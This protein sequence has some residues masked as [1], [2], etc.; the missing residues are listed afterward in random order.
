MTYQIVEKEVY[1]ETKIGDDDILIRHVLSMDA[2]LTMIDSVTLYK[3]IGSSFSQMRPHDSSISG[4]W[5]LHHDN[6]MKEISGQSWFVEY[7]IKNPFLVEQLMK[8]I[9]ANKDE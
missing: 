2:N 9:E 7:L 8:K 3:K 6:I 4:D 1:T 5:Q